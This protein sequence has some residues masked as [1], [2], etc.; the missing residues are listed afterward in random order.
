MKLGKLKQENK[1][2][3]MSMN[4]DMFVNEDG[5]V[6]ER[7]NMKY[8]SNGNKSKKGCGYNPHTT[9]KTNPYVQNNKRWKSPKFVE[10]LN[11]YDVLGKIHHSTPNTPTP[12]PKVEKKE[13]SKAT[14]SAKVEETTTPISRSY[15]CD[16][17]LTWDHGKMVVKYVGAY[18]K[19]EIIRKS[20]WVPKILTNSQGPKS[21]WVPKSKA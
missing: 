13:A 20:V 11:L 12:Q 10:G 4:M 15:M 21:F 1:F 8:L 9:Q 18:K 6:K 14:T 5:F 3:K 16:Y 2:L 7:L 17:M 19:R